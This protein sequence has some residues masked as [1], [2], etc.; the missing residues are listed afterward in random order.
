MGRIRIG[1]VD[2]VTH[3]ADVLIQ[4]S[5]L[6]DIFSIVGTFARVL[7]GSVD[8]PGRIAFFVQVVIKVIVSDVVRRGIHIPHP[9][10]IF[11]TLT[12]IGSAIPHRVNFVRTAY[13]IKALVVERRRRSQVIF[14]VVIP[15][16][17]GTVN[18]EVF[19]DKAQV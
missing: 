16:R 13:A 14:T 9:H 19:A 12:R 3:E 7:F 18:R 10:A 8:R 11:G 15:V 6:V 2:A 4:G 1:Q 17:R 5:V